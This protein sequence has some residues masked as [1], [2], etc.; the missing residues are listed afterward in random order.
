ML[1]CG[2]GSRDPKA[3]EQFERFA[4]QLKTYLPYEKVEIGYLEFARPILRESLDRLRVQG[5]V[6]ILAMPCLLFAAGHAKNDIPSV[7][8]QYKADYPEMRI[9]YGQDLG[10]TPEV[11]QAA[12]DRIREAASV[13]KETLLVVVGRGSSDPDANSNVAKL[14]RMLW[15]GTGAGWVETAYSG[16]AYPLVE[17]TLERGCRLGFSKVVVFPYFLFTGILVNRIYRITDQ[18][19]RRYPQSEFFK[20]SYLTDHP[21]VLK[22]FRERILQI[23]EGTPAMNCLLCQYREAIIGYEASVGQPQVGHHHAVEGL[24][25]EGEYSHAHSHSSPHAHSH[26]PPH[27]HS[28][29]PSHA[30]SHS[31]SY[32][33]SPSPSNAPSHAYSH[34]PSNAHPY[35]SPLTTDQPLRDPQEISRRS[36]ALI[37]KEVDLSFVPQELRPIIIRLIHTCGMTDIASDL[38]W[39]PNIYSATLNALHTQRP[40]LVDSEMVRAGIT[41][42]KQTH[43]IICTLSDPQTPALAQSQQTT[44]SAASVSLW[45]PYLTDAVVVIGTAPTA[46]FQLLQTLKSHP[47]AAI[48]AFPVGFVGARESKSQLT[49]QTDVPYLALQGRRGGSAL[50]AAALNGFAQEW[51]G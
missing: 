44:L 48:L 38:T 4:D 7:L 19:A 31:P 9:H 41:T 28:H 18:V 34:S 46:L 40:I 29:S 6:K 24:G 13:D 49:E 10:I 45:T 17:E 35:D 27:T 12:R 8:N 5:A 32:T 39:S 50:A 2:H 15:E 11:L 3:I 37:Q 23:E 36:F 30:H 43:Q 14:S 21:L 42:L 47:P 33:H 20:A 1:L 51:L 26:S 16:V 25:V 22:A